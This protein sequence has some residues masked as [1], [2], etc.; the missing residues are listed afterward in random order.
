MSDLQSGKINKG[1]QISARTQCKYLSLLRSPLIF[2][3][4]PINKITKKD[5]EH[6][7]VAV[8]FDSGARAEEIMNIR[9][10][11]IQ[12]PEGKENYIL[13]C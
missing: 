12:L 7:I 9:Y 8:L 10:E 4:K 13:T 5:L 3:N 2:F 6:F 11:D 1:V